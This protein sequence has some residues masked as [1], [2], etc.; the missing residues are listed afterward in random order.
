MSNHASVYP[1]SEST[2]RS[3]A[4]DHSPGDGRI[5][6]DESTKTFDSKAGYVYETADEARKSTQRHYKP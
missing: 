5:T 6:F 1:G 3:D 2:D 4:A